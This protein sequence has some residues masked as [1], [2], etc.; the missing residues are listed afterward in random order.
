MFA[1]ILVL[2]VLADPAG[3]V[4]PPAATPSTPVAAAAP[5]PASAPHAGRLEGSAILGRNRPVVGATVVVFAEDR[6]TRIHAATTDA[7]GH[8]EFDGLA[9]GSY[10]V[11]VSREGLEAVVKSH[12]ELRF[13]FRAVVEVTLH[14]LGTPPAV[15]AAPSAEEPTKDAATLVTLRGKVAET[16]GSPLAD[17][18][19]RLVEAQ[20]RT[21]PRITHS[22]ADG[23]FEIEGLAPGDWMLEARTVGFLPVRASV[24]LT[25]GSDKANEIEVRLARQPV[26]FEPTPLDLMPREEPIAPP[27]L[28]RGK[29]PL[30]GLFP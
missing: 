3:A 17:V 14:A 5:P 8:F 22:G 23:S 7:R 30:D 21:D 28:E 15:A 9:D 11:R 26:A 1:T 2:A 12:V 6:P 4:E 13:P 20:G 27:E 25:A 19:V 18:P 29:G 24:T 16:S 10:I